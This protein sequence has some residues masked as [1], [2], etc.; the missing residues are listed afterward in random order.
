LHT[1]LS[2]SNNWNKSKNSSEEN[3]DFLLQNQWNNFSLKN[4]DVNHSFIA[5]MFEE[6]MNNLLK[7][8]KERQLS[9]KRKNSF[10][11]SISKFFSIKDI[12]KKKDVS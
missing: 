10:R 9:K 3:I 2:K 5:Q 12:F 8:T 11:R 4:V 7:K 1:L 6:K